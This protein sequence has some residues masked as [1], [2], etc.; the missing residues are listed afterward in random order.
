MKLQC[1]PW[2]ILYNYVCTKI[3][4][5]NICITQIQGVLISVIKCFDF[6]RNLNNRTLK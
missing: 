2:E 4:N 6:I 1:S 5:F 3:L